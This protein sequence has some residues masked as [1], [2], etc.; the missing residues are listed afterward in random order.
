[1]RR[2]VTAAEVPTIGRAAPRVVHGQVISPASSHP[3][4]GAAVDRQRARRRAMTLIELLVVIA[5]IGVLI[6]LLLPAVQKVREAAI[7]TECKNKLHNLG[8]A[9]HT[10]ENVHHFFPRNTVRPRGV[11]P[12][13]G[14][15]P[16]NFSNWGSGT[17]ESWLREITPYF[18]QANPRTQDVL[19][20]LA[21]PSDPRGP[22]YSMPQYGFTWYVG[23]YSNPTSLNNGIII[24][25]SVLKDAMWITSAAITDGASNTIMIAERPPPADGQWGWWD[26]PCCTQDTMSPARGDTSIYSSGVNGNCPRPATYQFGSVVD[27]C[28]F[29]AVW[30]NHLH[31]AHFCMGDGSVRQIPYAA[32][33]EPIA[34][35]TLLEALASR[36]GNESTS[37]FD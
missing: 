9:C 35:I 11:T 23:I 18:E 10:F 20:I 4:N 21:C 34:S 32:G 29:N 27:N 13:D 14:Q 3:D 15:P 12:I 7:N 26:S 1:M 30:A 36:S 25:D 33:N 16:D 28:A 17:Y 24:D 22:T 31:G 37:L 2:D 19:T 6:A 8:L 5:I